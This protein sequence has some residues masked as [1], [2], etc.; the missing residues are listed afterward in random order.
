[1]SADT[2]LTDA[3]SADLAL[4]ARVRAQCRNCGV[5]PRLDAKQF[6]VRP[7]EGH[8]LAKFLQMVERLGLSF[9]HDRDYGEIRVDI[10]EPM[11]LA[12]AMRAEFRANERADTIMVPVSG[13]SVTLD[14]FRQAVTA[15]DFVAMVEG[16]WLVELVEAGRL[17]CHLQPICTINGQAIGHEFLA[18]AQDDDGAPIPAFRMIE[19]AST[20]RMAAYFDRSARL[21]AVDRAGALALDGRL[22]INFLPSTVYDPQS[23]L[24][25]TVAAIKRANIAPE[26]VV[27]EVVE[28]EQIEDVEH[29]RRIIDYYRDSG[30]RIALDD[31]GAGYNNLTTFLDLRP[32]FV[33]F[34]KA[35]TQAACKDEVAMAILAK[36]VAAVQ[37][38]GGQAILEGVETDAMLATLAVAQADFYQGYHFA[39]PGPEPVAM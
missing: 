34:D 15:R 13:E 22:F 32:D 1:M 26:R 36:M 10:G 37:D 6:L 12:A 31:F 16:R 25:S 11:A 19:A 4:A 14:D 23:C 2:G 20:P 24:R 8:S 5:P 21:T 35:I 3:L 17:T 7:P 38:S 27:F 28:T 18:R 33:K 29:L 30:F 39:K 9:A